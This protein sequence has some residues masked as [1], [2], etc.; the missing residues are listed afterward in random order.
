MRTLIWCETKLL[1]MATF[2]GNF[3]DVCNSLYIDKHSLVVTGDKRGTVTIWKP[4]MLEDQVLPELK[5]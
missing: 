4:Y 5:I 1:P 2:M 3:Q